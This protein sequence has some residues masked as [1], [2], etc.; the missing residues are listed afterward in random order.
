M[1]NNHG[2]CAHKNHWIMIQIVTY[3]IRIDFHHFAAVPAQVKKVKTIVCHQWQKKITFSLIASKEEVYFQILRKAKK[4]I[5]ILRIV[6][7]RAREIWDLWWKLKKKCNLSGETVGQRSAKL[8]P[9]SLIRSLSNATKACSEKVPQ[10]LKVPLKSKSA[11]KC[12]RFK[13]QD[14]HPTI[15]LYLIAHQTHS[16]RT[17]ALMGIIS[18]LQISS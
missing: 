3:K 13:C 15:I 1:K 18:L 6:L 12:S 9:S 4:R 8:D 16:K 11:L 17:T 14:K 5:L 7:V 10:N 2:L